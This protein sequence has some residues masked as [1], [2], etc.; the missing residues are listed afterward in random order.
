MV[1]EL[2]RSESDASQAFLLPVVYDI[3][4]IHLIASRL[5]PAGSPLQR[6]AQLRAW[7]WTGPPSVFIPRPIPLA[8]L[9]LDGTEPADSLTRRLEQLW[10]SASREAS[11]T[12]PRW[13]PAPGLRDRMSLRA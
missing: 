9:E 1:A 10:Y 6:L 4:K 13:S 7:T 2:A 11:A 8:E 12:M 3:S 5:F